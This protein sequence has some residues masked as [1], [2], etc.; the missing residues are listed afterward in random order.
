MK[1]I[2]V[3]NVNYALP[4]GIKLINDYGVERP[5]RDGLTKEVPEP[6]TTVY[7][8]PWERVLFSPIRDANPFFHF[9]ESLWIFVGRQDVDWISEFNSQ[10]H[11]YSDDGKIFHASYGHR[12]FI[13]KGNQISKAIQMLKDNSGSRRVVLQIWDSEIDLAVEKNDIPCND[14]IFLKIRDNKLNMTVCCRS[15]DLVFGTYGANAVHFAFLQEYIASMIGVGIGPYTQISDSYHSYI[16]REDWNRVQAVTSN[17]PYNY[18]GVSI[19]PLIDDPD[20]FN[21]DLCRFMG[22][23]SKRIVYHNSFFPDVAE[24]MRSAWRQHKKYKTGHEYLKQV[25]DTGERPNDWLLAGLQWMER[26]MT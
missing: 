20:S 24:L 7:L 18:N 26:R 10:I 11:K 14:L 1:T 4:L 25:I 12:L 17:N 5:S 21:Y 13:H 9:F 8:K 3:R 16:T 2:T 15:N 6:V 23:D 22:R 19:H